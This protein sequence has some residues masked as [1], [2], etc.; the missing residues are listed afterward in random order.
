MLSI[1]GHQAAHLVHVYDMHSSRD[2]VCICMGMGS[3]NKALFAESILV[4]V[5]I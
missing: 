1:A 3:D 4:C 5:N 2:T